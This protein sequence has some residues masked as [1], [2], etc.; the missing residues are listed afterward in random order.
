MKHTKIILFSLTLFKISLSQFDSTVLIEHVKKSIELAKQ[1]ISSLKNRPEIFNISGYSSAKVR[2]VL[3]NICSLPNARYLE[4]GVFKGSTFISALYNNIGTLA[5][6]IAIDDWSE[7]GG[8]RNEFINNTQHFLPNGSFTFY[9]HNCF[10]IDK[11]KVFQNPI[12][13]YFYDGNHLEDSH[14]KAFTLLDSVLADTFIA[15]VDDW[16]WTIVNSWTRVAF[17][18][19]N[20]NIL[21]EEQ[22]HSNGI[23]DASTWWNGFYIAV[24][25][26]PS[27]SKK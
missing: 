17:K 6:A 18:E 3:N 10:T 12:D 26:K 7:F 1:E 25:Q 23:N 9:D 19:L 16:D 13:I 27:V 22:L 14:K 21:Y 15:I 11:Q 4:I 24:I 2:H 5:Q 20:Y 8:P